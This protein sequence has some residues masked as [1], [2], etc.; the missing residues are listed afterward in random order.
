MWCIT[1][2]CS[3]C[4]CKDTCVNVLFIFLMRGI[5]SYVSCLNLLVYGLLVQSSLLFILASILLC[6]RLV[7]SSQ[8]QKEHEF[9]I[10]FLEGMSSVKQFCTQVRDSTVHLSLVPFHMI[11]IVII[12]FL[13]FVKFLF[14]VSLYQSFSASTCN[15]I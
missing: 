2:V 15:E 5:R 3:L 8:M 11:I 10:N 9:Y 1:E 6:C 12:I 13:W 4:Y 14:N 7:T